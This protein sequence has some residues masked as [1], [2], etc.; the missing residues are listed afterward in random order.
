[1]E[2]RQL[3]NNVP[4]DSK[5]LIGMTLISALCQYPKHRNRLLSASHVVDMTQ[6]TLGSA[7]A[8]AISKTIQITSSPSRKH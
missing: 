8:A 7:K 6:N 4:K 5:L 2:F 1:M 3:H